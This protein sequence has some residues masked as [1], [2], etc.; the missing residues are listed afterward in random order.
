MCC[1]GA[2]AQH[3]ERTCCA[4]NEFAP[5]TT[6]CPLD[7]PPPSTDTIFFPCNQPS[8]PRR[9]P[10]TQYRHGQSGPEETSVKNMAGRSDNP[11]AADFSS[12][13]LQRATH[14]LSEDLDNVRNADDFKPDSISFLVHA[15]RQ[16]AVQF[17]TE[18]QQRVV[19]DMGKANGDP[20]P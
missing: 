8:S 3:K 1:R 4:E 12:Y 6:H 13:Y 16:G 15:L 10:A 11:V 5:S 9:Q 19:S 20:S 14:E 2:V 17:S 18:D 7:S